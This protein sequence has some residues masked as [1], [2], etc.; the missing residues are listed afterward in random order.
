MTPWSFALVFAGALRTLVLPFEDL[1]DDR[2]QDWKGSVFEEALSS[3]L[4]SAGIAVVDVPARNRQLR[5]KGFAPGDAITRASAIVLAKDLGADR[6]VVGE[7]RPIEGKIEVVARLI[8]LTKGSTIGVV[9]DYGDA[10]EVS[11]LANL[12]AKNIFRLERDDVPSSFE[13]ERARRE[14]ISIAALEAGALARTAPD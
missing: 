1:S 7:F 8:D 6:L 11:H 10:G 3:H 13:T 12:V 2:S 14:K 5:E 9:E 4:E